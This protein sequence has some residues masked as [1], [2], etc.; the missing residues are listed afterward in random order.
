MII[1]IERFIYAAFNGVGWRFIKTPRIIEWLSEKSLEH[2][3]R[4]GTTKE[5]VTQTLLENGKIAYSYLRPIIDE[6]HRASM[7]N[8][9]II[10]KTEDLLKLLN[11]ENFIEK[12]LIKNMARPPEKLEPIQIEVG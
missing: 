11:A 12:F 8:Y 6:L 7:Y 4:Q 5:T 3:M 9:T 1:Q 2:L 10:L